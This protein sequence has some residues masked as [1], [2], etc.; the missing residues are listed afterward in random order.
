[1][2]PSSIP[3]PG[4]G[5]RKSADQGNAGYNFLH[6]STRIIGKGRGM[7]KVMQ[8]PFLNSSTRIIGKGRG[9]NKVMQGPLPSFLHQD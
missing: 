3:P 2:T 6:F 9:M 8:G 7:N 1:M 4:T 5:E